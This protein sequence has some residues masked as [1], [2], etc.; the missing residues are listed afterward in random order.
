MPLDY[1]SQ[2]LIREI[3]LLQRCEAQWKLKAKPIVD[4]L[5]A[6]ADKPLPDHLPQPPAWTTFE[7]PRSG[8]VDLRSHWKLIDQTKQRG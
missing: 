5:I 7:W 6:D 1:Y 4:Q 8:E 3:Q 2:R